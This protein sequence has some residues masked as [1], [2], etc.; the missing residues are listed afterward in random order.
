MNQIREKTIGGKQFR[1]TDLLT[2]SV[3][4]CSIS[5]DLRTLFRAE[6]IYIRAFWSFIQTW[7]LRNWEF[8]TEE[9]AFCLTLSTKDYTALVFERKL[10]VF[11][12]APQDIQ[13][14]EDWTE[15][16]CTKCTNQCTMYNIQHSK[17]MFCGYTIEQHAQSQIIKSRPW[18]IYHYAWSCKKYV[19]PFSNI[20][21][22]FYYGQEN[23]SVLQSTCCREEFCEQSTVSRRTLCRLDAGCLGVHERKV[24]LI[25]RFF[26]G[27]SLT[28]SLSFPMF[29]AFVNH[30]IL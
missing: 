17:G 16:K 5:E 27:D 7:S 30:V 10:Q 8:F 2:P 23:F 6:L 19:R 15:R 13:A 26:R 12:K 1:D 21:D 14:L 20:I 25:A 4:S 29:F 22:Q 24:S 28:T 11:K 9:E 18:E 3:Y